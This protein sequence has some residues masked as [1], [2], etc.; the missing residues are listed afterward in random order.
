MNKLDTDFIK[1]LKIDTTLKSHFSEW[2]CTLY[3]SSS[4]FFPSDLGTSVG[5][6]VFTLKQIFFTSRRWRDWHK[7]G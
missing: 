4:F 1:S 6:A 7:R 3:C 5:F 2:N